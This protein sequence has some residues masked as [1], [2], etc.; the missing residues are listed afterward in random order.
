MLN[1]QSSLKVSHGKWS[2]VQHGHMGHGVWKP[3]FLNHQIQIP[4]SEAWTLSIKFIWFG[5]LSAL[6]F[7]AEKTSIENDVR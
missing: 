3:G 5:H 4:N 7:Q 6:T 2:K 1:A